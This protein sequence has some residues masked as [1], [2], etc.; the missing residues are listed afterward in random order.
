MPI[1]E[2][3]ILGIVQ[4]LTEFIPVSS[5][6]HLIAIPYLFGWPEHPLWFDC[7]LHMGTLAAVVWYFRRDWLNI[8]RTG[9]MLVPII[10]ASVPAALIGWKLDDLIE[11]TLRE[12]YW[13]AGALVVIGVVMFVADRVGRKKR[14]VEEMNWTDYISIGCAQA[15]ALFPGVSRSGITITAGLFRGLDRVAAAR[16]SFLLSTPIIFGAGVM[17]LKKDVVDA[18][19][20]KPDQVTPFIV[21][22]ITSAIVGYVAIRFL[23]NYLQKRS[24]NAFVIYRIA[25]A[26]L[27]VAVFLVK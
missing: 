27:M 13:V 20:L 16:F 12:W 23:M 4:G 14:S 10:V 22:I 17:Q 3:I 21:G 2:A 8:L 5:T 9:R 25:F 24:L 26:A 19:G 18:G 1:I 11:K 15:L 7:A 6:G